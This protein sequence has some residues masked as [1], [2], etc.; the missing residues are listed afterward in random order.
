MQ[1][2]P[3]DHD[4]DGREV[5]PGADQIQVVNVASSSTN[6]HEDVVA[7]D[8]TEASKTA[9]LISFIFKI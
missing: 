3:E 7:H 4:E 6:S 8:A 2:P 9:G 1:S 5:Q